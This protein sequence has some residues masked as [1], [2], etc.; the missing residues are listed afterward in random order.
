MEKFREY[1]T[2]AWEFYQDFKQTKSGQ[3]VLN[4][5]KYYSFAIPI[6][7]LIAAHDELKAPFYWG[8]KARLWL[9]HQSPEE[10]MFF[11]A[12]KSAGRE[13][14]REEASNFWTDLEIPQY[15]DEYPSQKE[16]MVEHITH[17]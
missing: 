5:I 3:I 8:R 2:S 16:F 12:H 7:F 9:G 4:V 11:S 1:K 14:S 10:F 13:L 15:Y 17:F 6:C